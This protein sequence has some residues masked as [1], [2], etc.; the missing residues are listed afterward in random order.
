MGWTRADPAGSKDLQEN[1]RRRRHIGHNQQRDH[2]YQDQPKQGRNDPVYNETG[3]RRRGEQCI[4]EW[5]RRLTRYR[6]ATVR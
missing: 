3:D 2:F 5:R 4:A 6:A 1:C